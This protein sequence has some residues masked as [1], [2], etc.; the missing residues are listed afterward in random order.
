MSLYF[1]AG[2]PTADFSADE[3]KQAVWRTLD[4]LGPRQRVLALPPDITRVHSRAG[5]WHAH[6]DDPFGNRAHV[7]G[8][9]ALAVPGA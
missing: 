4:A 8:R 7:S 5:H 6:A 3:L 1:A 9:A 2:S